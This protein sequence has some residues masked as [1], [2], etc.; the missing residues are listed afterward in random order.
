MRHLVYAHDPTC[1]T[2]FSIHRPSF[3]TRIQTDG[4]D[5]FE[6]MLSNFPGRITGWGGCRF[7]VC[8]CLVL[9]P[10]LISR[11]IQID[12]CPDWIS[13]LKDSSYTYFLYSILRSRSRSFLKNK[14]IHR[15]IYIYFNFPISFKP[16]VCN[17]KFGLMNLIPFLYWW[18]LYLS[19]TPTPLLKICKYFWNV[20]FFV[21]F[22]TLTLFTF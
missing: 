6:A 4:M 3:R 13:R 19:I 2:L 11:N 20:S 16:L 5:R 12:D 10:Q 9:T 8:C 21:G 1:S 15:E 18:K 22:V 17:L 7:V 14:I